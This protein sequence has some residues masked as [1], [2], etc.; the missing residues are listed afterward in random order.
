MRIG[1]LKR[2]Q[3]FIEKI[4]ADI[5]DN[6]EKLR[7]VYSSFSD[8][9]NSSIDDIYDT[10]KKEFKENYQR[11]IQRGVTLVGP[12]RDDIKFLVNDK[13]VADFGSQGQQRS[14]ALSLKLAE[15]ELIK[16]EVGDY[17]ILLLDDVLSELDQK[18]QT[19]LLSSIGNNIQTFITTTSLEDV[20]RNLIKDPN[21]LNISNGIVQQEES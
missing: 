19:H 3:S 1:F 7:L 6:Q 13:N 16:E 4:H 20:D 10:Y 5:T 15:V 11:E 2:L 21:V 14:V 8:F 12:H 9:E 18:R 17:P